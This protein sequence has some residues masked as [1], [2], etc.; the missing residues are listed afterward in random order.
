ML[1]SNFYQVA[2]KGTPTDKFIEV[3]GL[4]YK[5]APDN[6]IPTDDPELP[7][8]ECDSLREN[9]ATLEFLLDMFIG[10][11]RWCNAAGKIDD[12]KA[13]CY[14]PKW[15]REPDDEYRKRIKRSPF[16]NFFAPAVKGFPGFLSD[17]QLENLY[18]DIIKY[19]KDI[20][21]QGSNLVSFLWQ[22]DLKVIR[23]GFC[24]I[25]VDMPRIPRDEKG[26]KLV[27]SLADQTKIE[28]R[29]YLVL[30]D[31]RDILS[32]SQKFVNGKIEIDRI[33]IREYV[34]QPLGRFGSQSITRYKTFWS[35][36]GYKIEV[37]IEKDDKVEALELEDGYSDLK[38]VP[39][40][41]YSA[42]DINPVEADPPLENLAEK[43]RAYYELYSEYREIIHKM[44]CPV[45]VRIGMLMPGG[46]NYQDLPDMVF[47]ANTGID[48]PA[49]GDFKFA[50]LSGA[51]L[52]T[53]R[54]ELTALEIA[55]NQ[56]SLK[57]LSSG[58]GERT[59]TEAQLEASQTQ[60]TLSGIATLKESAMEQ[61]AEK[62]AKYYGNKGQGGT[63]EISRDLLKM[64]LSEGEINALSALAVQKQ[65]S[66][67]TLLEILKE[68][69]R[70]PASVQ[71]E[72]EINRLKEQFQTQLEEQ[73]ELME[74]MQPE[75]DGDEVEEV[76]SDEESSNDKGEMKNGNP[77]NNQDKK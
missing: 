69:K 73:H 54:Q 47:G 44:N 48:V 58:S 8:Y 31:R 50:E 40:V 61:I 11:S 42:T 2:S 17:F 15:S 36:G 45:P 1:K 16:H 71:P 34:N 52:G 67:L 60:A 35:D 76:E 33:T 63:I 55:M 27:R 23:D 66:I 43:N 32:V 13:N 49:G 29:P 28:N 9:R 51:V 37:L 21:L 6:K 70:L 14:I 57:F 30:I 18:P 38:E 53:D 12:S 68:G 75:P 72:E 7:S 26:N 10:S 77:K 64:P 39:I 65:V 62:W 20:D 59:A 46:S 5:L 4:R 41:L 56:D 24:G 74:A 3:D 19:E 25:L 22:A